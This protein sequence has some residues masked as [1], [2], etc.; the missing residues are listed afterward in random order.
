MG[1]SMS[2]L[3]GDEGQVEP[4][5][6]DYELA[7]EE[8]ID[9]VMSYGR[10]PKKGTVEVDLYEFVSEH[11]DPSYALEICVGALIDDRS[12]EFRARVDR[13][14]E[15]I[16]EMLTKYLKDS[17]AVDDLATSILKERQDELV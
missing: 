6:R 10:Y 3:H 12:Y 9:D 8:I 14:R 11:R 15:T 4:T 7:L 5:E 2:E 13:E 1:E 17:D 16:R